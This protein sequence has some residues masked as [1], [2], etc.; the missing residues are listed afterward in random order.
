MYPLGIKRFTLD[1]LKIHIRNKL[2][3]VVRYP[4]VQCKSDEAYSI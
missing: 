2:N 1:Q 3:K 4:C